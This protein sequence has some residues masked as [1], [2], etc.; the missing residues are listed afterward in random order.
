MQLQTTFQSFVRRLYQPVPIYPLVTFRIAFGLMMLLSVLR[1]WYL[2][3][4]EDHY[5]N[6]KITFK[7]FGFEWVTLPP[8]WV[9]YLL[10]GLLVLGAVG[11]LIGFAYRLAALLHFCCFTYLELIDLTY[12]LNHYYFVSLV[13]LLLVFVPAAQAY[14]VDSWLQEKYNKT[15][16]QFIYFFLQIT[17][18]FSLSPTP[19]LSNTQVPQWTIWVFKGQIAIVYIYAGIA[20]MNSTWLLEALPLKIWLLAQDGMPILGK[21]FTWE[22][23]AY[24]FSWIGMLYDTTI[25]FWLA[26]RPTRLWAYASVVVFHVLTGL[27]FQIGVFPLVM[28]VGTLI[29]FSNEWHYRCLSWLKK[30]ENSFENSFKIHTNPIQ[31][32]CWVT[33][34]FIVYFLFQIIFPWRFLL[35]DGNLFWTE[36][37]YRFSWRVML[38]EKAGTATFYVQDGVTKREGVVDNREFL[39]PHQEKQMA[40]QPDMILQ[41]AHFLAAHYAKK[42]V[43]QPKVR[44]EVYITLNGQPSKLLF[45]PQLDLTKIQDSWKEKTWLY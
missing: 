33:S 1:F 3:W 26:W 2:G 9:V 37:G 36:Q 8:P 28:M 4:I 41:Y 23:T 25:I 34:G 27:L 21:L 38:M 24:A 11:I 31:P 17:S 45:D 29:F 35:Y 42:G 13:S 6:T 20:K 39:N 15:K 19:P 40:M 43:Q 12:Y 30:S 32:N 5:I 7:Y 14:S 16:A 10:H 44:A 22:I 18:F